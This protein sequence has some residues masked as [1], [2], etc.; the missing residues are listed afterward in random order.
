MLTLLVTVGGVG[1]QRHNNDV[2]GECGALLPPAAASPHLPLAACAAPP[3]GGHVPGPRRAGVASP[4][5]R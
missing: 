5:E 3:H 4:S 2:S 1:E